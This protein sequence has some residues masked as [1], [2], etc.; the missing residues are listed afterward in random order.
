MRSLINTM[1]HFKESSFS[2]SSIHSK[3]KA[4]NLNV[5]NKF[6]LHAIP[7]RGTASTLMHSQPASTPPLA[8][9]P[10]THPM[11]CRFWTQMQ[12]SSPLSHAAGRPRAHHTCKGVRNVA[13]AI[14]SARMATQRES[15]VAST[16]FAN[17]GSAALSGL[18]T[19]CKPE[20]EPRECC[21]PQQSHWARLGPRWKSAAPD[22]ATHGVPTALFI[23]KHHHAICIWPGRERSSARWHTLSHS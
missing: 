7:N 13:L 20:A 19:P 22:P 2:G 3:P 9:S 10:S 12:A 21:C 14:R 6:S 1:S 17:Q 11:R 18:S 4:P 16:V 5:Y 15:L 8:A 23:G